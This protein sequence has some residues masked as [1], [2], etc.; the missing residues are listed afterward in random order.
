MQRA[1]QKG[2]SRSRN[3]HDHHTALTYHARVQPE[4]KLMSE[5]HRAGRLKWLKRNLDITPDEYALVSMALLGDV[6]ADSVSDAEVDEL[7]SKVTSP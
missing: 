4:K 3:D 5:K 7:K 2:R 6:P 1:W